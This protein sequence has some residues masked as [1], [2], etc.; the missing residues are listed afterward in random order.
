MNLAPFWPLSIRRRRL[1]CS[2]EEMLSCGGKH[3]PTHPGEGQCKHLPLL[4]LGAADHPLA[5]G[6]TCTASL[7]L[8]I[9]GMQNMLLRCL[10]LWQVLAI[11]M[12]LPAYPSSMTTLLGLNSNQGG[13][14]C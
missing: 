9:C 1:A 12:V 2:E 6:G 3:P 13:A 4:S 7:V 10:A 11:H 8:E 5:V 14:S